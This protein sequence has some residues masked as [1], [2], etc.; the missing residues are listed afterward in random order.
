MA[1]QN[2]LGGAFTFPGTS[3][4]VNR[5]GYGAMQLAG[6]HVFGPPKDRNA[7]I[8]V[9]REAVETGINHI[10]TSDFY[11]PHITNG[12]VREALHPYAKDL[13][14]VTKVGARARRQGCVAAGPEPGRAG[15]RRA[16]QPAQS[17]PRRA[18]RGQLPRVGARRSDR[19]AARRTI[20]DTGEAAA[21]GPDPSPWRGAPSRLI[22]SRKARTI[23]PVV[24]VQNEYN[25]VQRRDD[26]LIEQLAADWDCVRV[27]LPAGRLHAAAIVCAERCCSVSWHDANGSRARMDAAP[28]APTCC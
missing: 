19:T 7:A 2:N 18:R 27:V 23:A 3:I 1:E 5:M 12:I 4:T 9:L 25:L 15:S 8:A 28:R 14:I 24:C 10:D 11:G 16:R 6:P 22:R 17:R 13:T 26:A 20:Y 21:A